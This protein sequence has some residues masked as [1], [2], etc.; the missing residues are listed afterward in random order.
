MCSDVSF[1]LWAVSATDLRGAPWAVIQVSDVFVLALDF[2]NSRTLRCSRSL[3]DSVELRVVVRD[4]QANI[5]LDG[6]HLRPGWFRLQA[7]RT[8]PRVRIADS[9][10]LPGGLKEIGSNISAPDATAIGVRCTLEITGD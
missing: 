7:N 10:R 4:D 6:K 2:P 9:H 8:S 3:Q 1:R 5:H